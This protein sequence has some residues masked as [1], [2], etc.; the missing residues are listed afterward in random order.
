MSTEEQVVALFAKANPLPHLD[1]LDPVEPLDVNHLDHLSRR[2]SE[3]VDIQDTERAE[4]TR[5]IRPRLL[6]LVAAA[7][8]VI[9]GLAVFFNR[10]ARF[11]GP[12]S[13]VDPAGADTRVGFIGLPP[14]GAPPS[15]PESGELVLQYLRDG[16]RWGYVY[17]DGRLIRWW[18]ANL[19]E[20]ANNGVTGLLEQRLTPGGVELLR[21]KILSTAQSV[22]DSILNPYSPYKAILI[23]DRDGVLLWA[24]LGDDALGRS[25]ADPT[26]W[27]PASAWADPEVR[28]YVPSRY[29]VCHMS[30]VLPLLP[31]PAQDLLLAK[32]ALPFPDSLIDEF[33]SDLT[34]E[35][36]RALAEALD[37]WL[38]QTEGAGGPG[39]SSW[40]QL[41]YRIDAAPGPNGSIWF[42]PYLPH[43]EVNCSHCG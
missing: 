14:E 13:L 34:T 4:K 18:H 35:E 27:L 20:G 3:M 42:E 9:V 28:A 25:N 23:R 36:A 8:I 2:S 11:V 7:V 24:H 6:P 39:A 37:A 32:E 22:D 38:E 19:P 33:C 21:S 26:S 30:G 12:A 40:Y 41:S 16:P 10:D 5:P 17:A 1:L 29:Q 43:G 15:T 31:A